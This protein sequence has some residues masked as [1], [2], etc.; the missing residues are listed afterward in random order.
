M[1]TLGLLQPVG[2]PDTDVAP[3]EQLAEGLGLQP[4]PGG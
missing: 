3:V 4:M 2:L 1:A